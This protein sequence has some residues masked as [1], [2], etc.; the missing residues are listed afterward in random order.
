MK[1][2]RMRSM[3]LPSRACLA[4]ALRPMLRTRP[5]A[6]RCSRNASPAIP[7]TE[8]SAWDRVCRESSVDK[9]GEFPGFHYS[10]AM[11]SAGITWNGKTLDAYV[12]D[13]QKAVPGNVMP[14][15]GVVDAKQRADLIA[16]LGTLK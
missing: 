9:S 3:P 4:C 13:P 12:A 6:S 1:T 15:S 8:R 11:K 5:R 7:S 16:Y 14:F 2:A 10:R